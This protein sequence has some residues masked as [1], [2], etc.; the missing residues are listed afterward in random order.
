MDKAEI[1]AEIWRL[2]KEKGIGKPPIFG[3]IPNFIGSEKAALN[4]AKLDIW[5]EARVLKVNPDSPQRPVR[6]RALEEGKKVIMPTPRI[7]SGFLLL[8]PNYIPRDRYWEASTIRGAFK[9]GKLIEPKN[10]PKIDLVVIG[11][12]AVNKG[13]DRLGKSEG[14][15]EIE[16]AIAYEEGKVD[17]STPVV[18]TVHDIQVVP[19]E[20]QVMPY[21]LPVDL[22]ATPTRIIKTERRREKPTGI[23]W[24]LLDDKKIEEIPILKERFKSLMKRPSGHEL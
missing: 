3:R 14:Y 2:L 5:K 24:N 18:T 13:G 11:S 19:Y 7:R 23:Y 12:V 1:R 16:W 8:D 4:L 6:E 15:A 22:I 17:Q 20:F 9:W 10:F 21:D